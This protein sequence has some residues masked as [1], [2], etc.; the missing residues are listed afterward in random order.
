MFTF[1][2]SI[3][4]ASFHCVYLLLLTYLVRNTYKIFFLSLYKWRSNVII[5]NSVFLVI[6]PSSF[7]F[8]H[9]NN[10]LAALVKSK[11]LFLFISITL[12]FLFTSTV[13]INW[14]QSRGWWIWTDVAFFDQSMI[15]ITLHVFVAR[16]HKLM[17]ICTCWSCST[18]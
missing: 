10:S 16:N 6:C 15:T 1:N 14:Y 2:I 4:S 13:P 11:N 17:I 9:K 3:L 8:L 7:T 5:V 18:E 12:N